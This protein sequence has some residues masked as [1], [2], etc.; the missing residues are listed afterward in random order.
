MFSG[1]YRV[2]PHH[3]I[4][5]PVPLIQQSISKTIIVYAR[6]ESEFV[7]P[8]SIT[9]SP[10]RIPYHQNIISSTLFKKR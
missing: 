10:S 2:G 8:K 3:V 9:T 5:E 4:A 6:V 7:Q 1:I